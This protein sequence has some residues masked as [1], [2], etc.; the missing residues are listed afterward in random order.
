MKASEFGGRGTFL[1]GGANFEFSK[2]PKDQAR[3]TN[4]GPGDFPGSRTGEFFPLFNLERRGRC[5]IRKLPNVLRP[6]FVINSGDVS[7]R[8]S[9]T[10][11]PKP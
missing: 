3:E 8:T 1:G 6:H 10:I 2:D 9:V 11:V 7:S 4:T 5:G